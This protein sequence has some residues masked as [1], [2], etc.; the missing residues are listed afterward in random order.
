MTGT[1]SE[2]TIVGMAP[3]S[4][5]GVL[6]AVSASFV[7]VIVM[8][9]HRIDRFADQFGVVTAR[10]DDFRAEVNGRFDSVNSRFDAV[11]HRFDA[12]DRRFDAVNSRF[13]AVNSRIDETNTRI[14]GL[15]ARF[16]GFVDETRRELRTHLH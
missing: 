6:S 2:G 5:F 3:W 7:T 16:D 13:D 11:D 15:T 8:L 4:T 1:Q 12:V 10:I 14:D 9:L